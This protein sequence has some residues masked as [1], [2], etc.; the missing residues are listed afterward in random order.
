M[1]N[2]KKRSGWGKKIE[3]IVL[4][5]IVMFLENMYKDIK[6]GYKRIYRLIEIVIWI[7]NEN[8]WCKNY[9]NDEVNG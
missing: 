5:K 3:K 6:E 1:V 9:V 8:L 7:K 4:I 2:E